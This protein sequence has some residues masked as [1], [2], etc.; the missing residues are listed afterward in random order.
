MSLNYDYF[1]L[2][3]PICYCI[4]QYM[5]IHNYLS[6]IV[7][8]PLL[9]LRLWVDNWV[10]QIKFFVEKWNILLNQFCTICCLSKRSLNI[11]TYVWYK[12]IFDERRM[13]KF[14]IDI[15]DMTRT[16]IYTRLPNISN[17]YVITINAL[18]L[19]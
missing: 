17:P 4:Y 11:W 15:N 1:R 13:S 12:E 6:C 8:C 14:E 18:K 19:Q 9:L 3:L 16:Y 7:N 5:Y 10:L 2:W